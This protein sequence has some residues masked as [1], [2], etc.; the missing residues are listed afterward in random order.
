MTTGTLTLGH[1]QQAEPFFCWAVTPYQPDLVQYNPHLDPNLTTCSVLVWW[2]EATSVVEQAACRTSQ[3][4]SLLSR[5][6]LATY[7]SAWIFSSFS[8]PPSSP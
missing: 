6:L 4:C 5:W 1:D 8:S 2:W 7:S 3:L